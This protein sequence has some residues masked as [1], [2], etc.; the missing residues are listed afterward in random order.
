MFKLISKLPTLKRT[1]ILNN[2]VKRCST[3]NDS[4]CFDQNEIKKRTDL[5][6]QYVKSKESFET[7]EFQISNQLND[8]LIDPKESFRSYQRLPI[9]NSVQEEVTNEQMVNEKSENVKFEMSENDS[10]NSY[11][12]KLNNTKFDELID[13]IKH[14]LNIL[15]L[16]ELIHPHITQL[17]SYQIR[18]IFNKINDLSYTSRSNEINFIHFKKTMEQS[19]VFKLLLNQVNYSLINLEGDC[20][21]TLLHTFN[22][23]DE[24]IHNELI[25]N[26]VQILRNKLDSLNLTEINK[27]LFILSSYSDLSL[28]KNN[29]FKLN[30]ELIESAR[31]KILNDEFNHKDINT[32]TRLF[33]VFLKPENDRDH[34]VITHLTEL[35]LPPTTILNL[36]QS[37][38][39]LRRIKQ[40]HVDFRVQRIKSRGIIDREY[41]LRYRK[42]KLFPKI[43]NRLIEKCNSSIYES[44]YLDP[45][46]ENL[47]FYFVNLHDSVD[48][49]NYEFKNFYDPKLL[50][51]LIPYVMRIF[52]TKNIYKYYTY[53]LNTNYAQFDVFDERLLKLVYDNYLVNQIFRSKLEFSQFYNLYTKYRFSF[54]NHQ[55][56]INVVTSPNSMVNLEQSLRFRLNSMKCLTKALLN[57][58]DNEQFFMQLLD[59]IDQLNPK[60]YSQIPTKLYKEITLSNAI[61]Q[62]F[63]DLEPNL[64][65]KIIQKLNKSINLV[66]EAYWRPKISDLFIR[67][68]D[69]L[70]RNGYLSNEVF[71]DSFGIYDRSIQDFVSLNGYEKYFDSQVDKIPLTEDQEL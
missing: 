61:V 46:E 40:S 48:T 18:I 12:Q 10:E 29:L 59:V 54:F 44:F 15:N 39:I 31:T 37:V 25:K 56:F 5:R 65:S 66:A 53:D 24:N 20:L 63:S 71:L 13:K 57:D 1:S 43:L 49:I 69:K 64:K 68:N 33:H 51:F 38:K 21:I 9:I 14:S 32:I 41:E 36:K 60:Y 4:F 47:H 6:N 11:Y 70:Q 35:L 58:V 30:Q 7:G 50:N 19:M 16:F 52:E 17:D 23:L 62:I 67:I 22:L 34:Q 28:S 45:S 42:N 8:D 27:C 3:A 2:F 26:T 55:K